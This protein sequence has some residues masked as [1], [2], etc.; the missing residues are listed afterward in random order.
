MP[1]CF[2][3][4][5]RRKLEP[6]HSLRMFRA[7][8]AEKTFQNFMIFVYSTNIKKAAIQNFGTEWPFETNH[9]GLKILD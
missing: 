5:V 1:A 4:I 2:L 6:P 3:R 7:V 9:S 8:F